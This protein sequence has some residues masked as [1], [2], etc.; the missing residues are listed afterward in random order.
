ML[1]EVRLFEGVSLPIPVINPLPP[2][3]ITKDA[4]GQIIPYSQRS[5]ILKVERATRKLLKKQQDNKPEIEISLKTFKFSG[6]LSILG[7]LS[8]F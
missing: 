1:L 4:R 8:N 6:D 5:L 7:P 2:S 3:P